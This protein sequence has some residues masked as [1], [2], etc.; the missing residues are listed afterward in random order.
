MREALPPPPPPLPAALPLPPPVPEELPES[1][2]AIEPLGIERAGNADTDKTRLRC[3]S[4]AGS[5][6]N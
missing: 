1:D 2:M 6:T 3:C 5:H 4:I